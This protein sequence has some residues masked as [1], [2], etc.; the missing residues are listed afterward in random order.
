MP[1]DKP[2]AAYHNYYEDQQANK[3]N[4]MLH[5]YNKYQQKADAIRKSSDVRNPIVDDIL[6]RDR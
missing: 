6:N 1:L 2:R 5:N 3:E 4:I